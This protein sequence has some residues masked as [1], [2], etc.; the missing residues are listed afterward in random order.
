MRL[1]SSSAS[2]YMVLVS[3]VSAGRGGF[4]KAGAVLGEGALIFGDWPDRSFWRVD[5]IYD[6]W[7]GL[8]IVTALEL[9]LTL[10]DVIRLAWLLLLPLGLANGPFVHFELIRSFSAFGCW[11]AVVVLLPLLANSVLLLVFSFSAFV[12]RIKSG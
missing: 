7:L 8:G 5:D 6:D 11:P 2:V 12:V 4:L 10:L 3:K 1:S 9:L